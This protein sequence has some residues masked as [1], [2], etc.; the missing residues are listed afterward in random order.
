MVITGLTITAF[1]FSQATQH[2]VEKQINDPARKANAG[3]ADKIIA[4]K[5]NIFDSTTFSNNSNEAT[6]T[7]TVKAGTRHKHCG[8]K[9]KHGSKSRILKKKA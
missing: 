2:P 8:T 1:S 9:T 5:K 3:K 4:N 7:K 6:N